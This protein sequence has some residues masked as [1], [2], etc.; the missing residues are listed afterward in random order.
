M[1]LPAKHLRSGFSLPVYGLGTWG[2]GGTFDADPTGDAASIRAIRTALEHGVTHIDTAE[3]YGAGHTEEVVGAAIAGHDRA[4]LCLASKALAHHLDYTGLIAA[5]QNSLRRLNTPYLDLYMVHHPN[6]SIPIA[7]TMRAL[8]F[9]VDTGQVRH[10]GV[11]NF[12]RARLAEAQHHSRYPIVVNQVH[13]NL[14]VREPET[15]GLL[16]YCRDHD[17]LLVAWKPLVAAPG[18]VPLVR[19]LARK[20]G[21]SPVQIALNW[22]IAQENVVLISRTRDA[23]HLEENLGA[24]GWR[25]SAEDVEVL[26]REFPHQQEKSDTFALR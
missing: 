11:S 6:D 1:I 18:D 26:R 24:V 16:P 8:A 10:I 12:S 7:E 4:A 9:L 17:V 20:Y 5:A 3:M 21:K 14:A 13:Y 23:Q 2:L 19:A 25:L 22:L 15:S